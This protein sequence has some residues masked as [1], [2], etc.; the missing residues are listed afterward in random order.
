MIIPITTLRVRIGLL[1]TD[2]TQDTE[3]VMIYET[4]LAIIE[5]YCDR[6]FELSAEVEKF[7]HVS[8]YSVQLVRYPITQIV[9][10]RNEM[11]NDM[12]NHYDAKAGV[13]QFDGHYTAHELTVDY[14]GGYDDTTCPKDLQLVLLGLFDYLWANQGVGSSSA[15]GAMKQAKIGDLSVSFDTSTGYVSGTDSYINA[16]M[17]HI[18]MN[19]KR[20]YV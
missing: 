8:G 6:K 13:V 3:I 14:E 4:A 1:E 11:A 2:G 7:T 15:T 20:W 16:A 17:A 5:N 18:L 19:Y 10:V 12:P 9:S